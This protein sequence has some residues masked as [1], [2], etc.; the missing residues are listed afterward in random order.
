MLFGLCKQ[1]NLVGRREVAPAAG[2]LSCAGLFALMGAF[3]TGCGV[4][5]AAGDEQT[6]ERGEVD[7]RNS[8]RLQVIEVPVSFDPRASGLG[9]FQLA[10]ATRVKASITGCSSGF[11]TVHDTSIDGATVALFKGDRGCV[12]KLIEFDLGGST[13]TPDSGLAFS[14]PGM[15]FFSNPGQTVTLGLVEFSNLSDPVSAADKISFGK[16]SIEMG[17]DNQLMHHQAAFK[18]NGPSHD[19]PNFEFFSGPE[20]TGLNGRRGIWTFVLECQAP[21]TLGNTACPSAAS[22]QDQILT[23]MAV[24]VSDDTL[25]GN[26]S[27]Y[28]SAHDV[29]R[30]NNGNLRAAAVQITGAQVTPPSTGFNGGLTFTFATSSFLDNVSDYVLVVTSTVTGGKNAF[31]HTALTF[32]IAPGP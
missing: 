23:N 14:G 21:L 28:A 15:A 29:I 30:Q 8:A 19:A 16:E 2:L 3:A 32:Q 25:V 9:G 6:F 27:T 11:S 20:L 24:I 13:Y 31:G 12:G 4:V 7:V 10:S 5:R 17:A 26:Y 1:S 18:H 22:A